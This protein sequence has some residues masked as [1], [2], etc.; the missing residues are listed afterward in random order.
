MKPTKPLRSQPARDRI[1]AAARRAF[2]SQGYDQVTVRALAADAKVNPAMAIRYFGSKE[3]VFAAVATFDL[4]LPALWDVP[5][6][7]LGETL[8][9]HFLTRWE[10]RDRGNEL[11][12]LLRASVSH[13]IAR[14]K[15]IEI[16]ETQLTAAIAVLCGPDEA[17]VR[18]ALVASQML[19]IALTKYVVALP[20]MD[21]LP[22]DVLISAVGATLQSYL[23][24]DI[25]L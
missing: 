15:L 9:A 10:E 12:A 25:P 11:Q 13:D 4:R 21:D 18:A 24:S 6:E 5:R 1:L 8:V 20:A 2:A 17:G 23:T 14:R 7:K 3:G 16:F 19:G 22:A